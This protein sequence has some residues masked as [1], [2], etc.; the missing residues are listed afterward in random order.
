MELPA[1][2]NQS[3]PHPVHPIDGIS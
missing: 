2:M 1:I 3:H